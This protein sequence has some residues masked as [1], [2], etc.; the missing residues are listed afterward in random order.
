MNIIELLN[1]EEKKMITYRECRDGETVF[2]EDESC[3]QI[4]IVLSGRIDIV[5]YL[6]NGKSVL[7]NSLS[8]GEIFGNNLIFSSRP[9]YRGNISSFGSSRLGL[10]KK[11]DLIR[12]L[13]E[14]SAFLV[15]YLKIQSD[16]SKKLNQ[17]I[18]LLSIDSAQERLLYYL[19][20]N[21]KQISYQ[22]ITHL[23]EILYLQR[24]T[25]SRV[26]NRLE[27]EGKI[28]R[29]GHTIRLVYNI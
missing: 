13:Q 9:Y 6:E 23:S 1:E 5:S 12:I 21:H 29:E 14:N 20:A 25:L 27:K 18:R 4:G 8:E 10:I 11:E 7:Y 3:T 15:E 26:L 28:I 17:R 2:L 24:E 16:F 22:S 19:H